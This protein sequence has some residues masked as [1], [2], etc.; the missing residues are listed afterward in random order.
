MRA[1]RTHSA[2]PVKY[3]LFVTVNDRD[4]EVKVERYYCPG[5]GLEIKRKEWNQ[6][7]CTK[8]GHWLDWRKL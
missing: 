4:E 1:L 3:R 5:C 2:K 8:C 7:L 6:E